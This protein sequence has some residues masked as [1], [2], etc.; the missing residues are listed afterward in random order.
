MAD[1][2]PSRRLWRDLLLEWLVR[3]WENTP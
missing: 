2:V 3:F 1:R